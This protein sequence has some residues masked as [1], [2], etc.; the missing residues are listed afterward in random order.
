MLIDG[1]PTRS[2]LSELSEV[3][4]WYD[5]SVDVLVTNPTKI[6]SG[7]LLTCSNHIISMLFLNP[8]LFRAHKSIQ[9]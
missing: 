3:M 9:N 8:A 5:R 6:T 7:A 4:P 1:G 2:M